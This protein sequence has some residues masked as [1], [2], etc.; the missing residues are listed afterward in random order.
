MSINPVWIVLTNSSTNTESSSQ[1]S[2]SGSHNSGS[3]SGQSASN[4]GTNGQAANPTGQSASDLGDNGETGESE[5]TPAESAD[6]KKAVEINPGT[7]Q[8]ASEVGLSIIAV[9]GVLCLIGV[10]ALGYFRNRDDE[11]KIKDLDKLFN[12]KVI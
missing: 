9:L 4:V 10:I 7:A 6:V 1:S 3:S 2:G 5:S 8:S 12:E 11:E